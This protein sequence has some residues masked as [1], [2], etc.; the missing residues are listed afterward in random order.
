[1][2]RSNY[3]VFDTSGLSGTLVSASLVLWTGTYE[4]SDPSETFDVVAP[5]D[6][7][8]ALSDADSLLIANAAGS[9]EFDESG[10][11]AIGMASA[12]YG[13]I[14]ASP[15]LPLGSALISSSL[16]DSFL[17]IPL[18]DL[19]YISAFLGGPLFLGGTVPTADPGG[20][21]PQQPFGFTGPD[22]PGGIDPTIPVLILELESVLIPE[23]STA[24][25]A[26][27]GL[28]AFAVQNVRRA[29]AM[30]LTPRSL[31][32]APGGRRRF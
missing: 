4:S 22:V 15:V 10:D 8:A 7:G 9:T 14:A 18:T 31:I 3:F 19:T 2:D 30:G 29:R 28:V 23:P 17:T 26:L 24:A 32:P 21:T 11:P 12:L 13:N 1:M 6:P 27:L 25:L 5:L 20:A 16:D